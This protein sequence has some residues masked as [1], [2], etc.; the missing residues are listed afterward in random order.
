VR[1][2]TVIAAMLAATICMCAGASGQFVAQL[3][4]D[5]RINSFVVAP[6]GTAWMGIGGLRGDAEIG[7]V[8]GNG[9]F[10]TIPISTSS[11]DA[12]GFGAGAAVGPSGEVWLGALGGWLYRVASGHQ[13]VGIGPIRG[14]NTD[15]ALAVGED[16]TLWD[17][18]DVADVFHIAA[19]GTHWETLTDA[20]PCASPFAFSAA[21]ATDGAMWIADDECD[22]LLRLAPDGTTTTIG[23]PNT[24][25]LTVSATLDGGV[26]FASQSDGLVG[27]AMA[28]GALASFRSLYSPNSG[29]ATAPDGSAWYS[30]DGECGITQLLDDGEQHHVAAPLAASAFF[31]VDGRP[32]HAHG[33]F[34]S[35]LKI[36]RGRRGTVHVSVPAPILNIV[37]RHLDTGLHVTMTPYINATDREGNVRFAKGSAQEL[38]ISR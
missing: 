18:F 34:E 19:N 6:D 33:Y 24:G 7:H 14:A 17:A 27:S 37:R 10:S 2:A 22:R 21:R 20:A 31:F 15:A 32:L 28:D 38:T 36:V 9:H 30:S 1:C 25:G 23:L 35:P 29:L 4:L 26:W 5:K 16:G 8:S 12:P 13:A 11:K 3:S